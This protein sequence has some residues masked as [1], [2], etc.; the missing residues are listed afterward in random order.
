MWFVVAEPSAAPAAGARMATLEPRAGCVLV[1]RGRRR[2]RRPHAARARGRAAA[3]RS[4]GGRG[5]QPA[6]DRRFARRISRRRPAKPSR[7]YFNRLQAVPT[8]H[9]ADPGFQAVVF[10]RPV[11]ARAARADAP[12]SRRPPRRILDVGCGAGAGIAGA[13][14][15]GIRPGTSRASRRIPGLAA[16]A[17][18]RCD[19]VLE[20]DLARVLAEL[21]RAGERFDALVFADVLEHL[22]DP[23]AALALGRPRRRAGR[24]PPRQR[25]ERRAPLARPRPRSWAASIRSPRASTDAGHL[26]W[27]TRAFL[28]EALEESGWQVGVDRERAAARRPPDAGDFLALAAAWPDLRSREPRR[29][30][31]G[32]R[33]GRVPA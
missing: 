2:S 15:P 18:K 16:R 32:S 20:G 17:R 1:G 4:G 30:T 21:G 8:P 24:A 11:G 26:R 28:E 27:F 12:A 25:P 5:P 13:Q 14:R 6:G 19:R 7:T 9:E 29:R 10:E 3:A 22:E 31:S 23:V 33:D